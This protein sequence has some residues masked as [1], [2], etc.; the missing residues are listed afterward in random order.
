MFHDL[1][2]TFTSNRPCSVLEKGQQFSLKIFCTGFGNKVENFYKDLYSDFNLKTSICGEQEFSKGG[3][4][5]LLTLCL[6]TTARKAK[7]TI[8]EST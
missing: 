1:A 5:C 7:G 6:V 2:F 4:I 8:M 3:I